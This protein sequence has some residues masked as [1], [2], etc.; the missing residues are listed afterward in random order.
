MKILLFNFNEIL[1]DVANELVDRGHTILPNDGKDSTWKKADVAVLWNETPMGGWDVWIQK[2]RKNKIR[3]VLVQHGR[4]GTSRIHPPFNEP[5]QSDVVCVWGDNDIK[6]LTHSGVPI[7]KILKTGTTIFGN[8]K[9]KKPHSG[10]NVVFSPEHWDADVAE[11]LI[12][13]RQLEK[14]DGKNGITVISKLLIDE[15]TPNM[16]P[17]PVWSDR[18]KNGHLS[19]C[20]DVL[21]VADVVV[22]ISESTFELL[23]EALDIPV[24]IADIWV[25][26]ACAG[27]ERYRYYNREFS[28]ACHR[29]KDVSK[30]NSAVLEAIKHP[31]KL[32]KER[33]EIVVLDGGTDVENPL[34]AIIKVIENNG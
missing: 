15:H 19:I 11:N 32:K 18:R 3:T 34:E 30:L 1:T 9:P 6:R 21:S 8:L 14:L 27:D 24:V 4:R 7:S 28:D 10:I 23:A 13:K 29:V 2:L 31:E 25:P 12:V 26:K 22:A 20:T 16:Y 17:N 5:L 33:A